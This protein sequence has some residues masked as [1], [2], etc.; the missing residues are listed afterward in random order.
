MT[1]LLDINVLIA[2]ADP[3]HSFHKVTKQWFHSQRGLSWATCPITENGFIRIVSQYAYQGN[4]LSPD[5]VRQT[6]DRMCSQPGHQFWPDDVSARETAKLPHL[7]GP[8]NLTDLYLLA[9]AVKHEGKFVSL[10]A[11]IDASLVPSGQNA[12]ILI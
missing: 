7:P 3:L 11:G 8:K 9:L 10:D 5:S 4:Q 2:L 6:L 12:F 1:H